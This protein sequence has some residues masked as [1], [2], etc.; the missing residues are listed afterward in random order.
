MV[1]KL[2]FKNLA[3]KMLIAFTVHAKK[4][5]QNSKYAKLDMK[6]LKI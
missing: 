2:K 3:L 1:L 5:L 4:L 6:K